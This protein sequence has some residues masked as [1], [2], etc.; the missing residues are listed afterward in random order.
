MF[1][2]LALEVEQHVHCSSPQELANTAWAFAAMSES[3]R[4][5]WMALAQTAKQ[6]VWY[7]DAQNLANTVWAFAIV[8]WPEHAMFGATISSLEYE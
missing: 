8:R 2:A 6:L 1:E 7:S 5:L 3:G 4:S